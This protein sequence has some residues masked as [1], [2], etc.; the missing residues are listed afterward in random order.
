M[1]ITIVT[2]IILF[3]LSGK[4]LRKYKEVKV[5]VKQDEMNNEN[6]E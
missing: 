3:F 5:P 4:A 2:A 6:K 1:I